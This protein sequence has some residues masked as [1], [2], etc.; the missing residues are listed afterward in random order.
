MKPRYL[1]A[2]LATTCITLFQACDSSVA[3]TPAAG[4]RS[5]QGKGM[6]AFRMSPGTLKVLQSQGTSFR[7][8]VGGP[9]METTT[10]YQAFD[11]IAY[12]YGIPCGT[13]S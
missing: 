11:T 10:S 2:A 13:R 4:D 6:V 3:A 12:A 7:I 5:S 9:G 8:E 1:L